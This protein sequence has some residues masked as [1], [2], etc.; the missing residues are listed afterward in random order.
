MSQ[1]PSAV[2]D[3]SSADQ[4]VLNAI[5][6]MEPSGAAVFVNANTKFI[7]FHKNLGVT[8]LSEDIIGT[9]LKDYFRVYLGFTE[10]QVQTRISSLEQAVKTLKPYPFKEVSEHPGVPVLVL[11]SV[12]KP[13]I[14]DA[15]TY[16]IWESR[17]YL[18][19]KL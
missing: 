13:I 5:F 6:K 17:V 1:V 7:A 2:K 19:S 14:V 15:C 4:E 3:L 18:Q 11:D 12:W 9:S 10:D 16:V 8:I